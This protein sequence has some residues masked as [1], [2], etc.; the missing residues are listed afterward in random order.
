MN[1]PDDMKQASEQAEAGLSLLEGDRT[2]VTVFMSDGC[3][4]HDQTVDRVVQAAATQEAIRQ[5][6]ERVN[7]QLSN[8]LDAMTRWA[9]DTPTVKKIAGVVGYGVKIRVLF[10]TEGQHYSEV[11]SDALEALSSEVFDLTKETPFR[12]RY[13]LVPEASEQAARETF[14]SDVPGP[15]DPA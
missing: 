5:A 12:F 2:A 14:M 13:Y 3:R 11:A 6:T 4:L 10:I 15:S 7:S 9:K 1:K 8:A